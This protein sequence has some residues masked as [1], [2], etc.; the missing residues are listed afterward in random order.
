MARDKTQHLDALRC[1]VLAAALAAGTFLFHILTA[2]GYGTFRDELYYLASVH[3]LDFGYV[4]HPPMVVLVAWVARTVLGDSLYAVRFF[5]ALAAG[6]T[7]YLT[8]AMARQ[9]GGGRWAQS[10]AALAVAL[11]PGYIGLFAVL[12]MNAF[13]VLFWAMAVLVLIRILKTRDLRLWWIFGLVAGIGLQNKISI[14]FLGFG[15]ITGLLITRDWSHFKSPW[16][17][18]GGALTGLIFA[19]HLIWQVANHWPTP[20]FIHNATTY[21]NLPLSPLAFMGEQVLQMNPMS[22][23][24]WLAG[25]C[26]YLFANRGRP[27]RALGLAYLIVALVMISQNAKPYYL[28]PMYPMLFVSGALV[29]GLAASRRGWAWIKPVAPALLVVTGLLAAPLAKP[30]LPV[31]L[32]VDYAGALGIAPRTEERNELGR[33]PQQYADMHGWEEMAEAVAGVYHQLSPEDQSAACVLG[34][35]YGEAGAIDF[36]GERYGLPPAISGHNSYFLWGPGE[37]TGEVMIVIGDDREDL[38]EVF[39]EVTEAARFRC[40]N[41]MPYENNLPLWICRRM[42]RPIEEVWPGIKK[43]I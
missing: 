30:L 17:W 29:V 6:V 42:R 23:P 9:L 31:D 38:A 3:H 24:L 39:E 19:P 20:E 40:K 7:V 15:V 1:D 16:L 43:F 41:C 32:L 2:Q 8:A 37:C 13:D 34:Q 21:K 4:E 36:F 18:L 26:F 27:Y 5:P 10:M 33:L 28:A 12:T 22:L 25:L 14:L 35:N 11:A